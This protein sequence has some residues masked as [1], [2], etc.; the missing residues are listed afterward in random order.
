MNNCVGTS[1]R[2]GP[3]RVWSDIF[4]GYTGVSPRIEI[5]QANAPIWPGEREG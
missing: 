1:Q 5:T 4:N 3:I 2:M